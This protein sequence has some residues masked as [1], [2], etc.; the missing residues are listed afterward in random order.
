MFKKFKELSKTER[1]CVFGVLLY[2][3]IIGFLSYNFTKKSEDL[4]FHFTCKYC[5]K[6]FDL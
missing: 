5:K 2:L 3:I 4:K 6:E 1:I